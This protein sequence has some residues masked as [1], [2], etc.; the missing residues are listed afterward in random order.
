M[1]LWA[2]GIYNCV[3]TGGKKVSSLQIEKLTRLCVKIVF[4]FDKDVEQDEINDLANRFIDS[5]EIYTV[6][7]D[8]NILSEKESPT[9]DKNKLNRLLLECYKKIR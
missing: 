3:A 6:I 4:L 9:D 1:Q 5:V 8:K 7:D 2:M